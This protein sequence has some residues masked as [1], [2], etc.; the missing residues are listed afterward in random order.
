MSQKFVC[1]ICEKEIAANQSYFAQLCDTCNRSHPLFDVQTR[2]FTVETA[3]I[4]G[5]CGIAVNVNLSAQRHIDQ[6]REFA[7]KLQIWATQLMRD[8]ENREKQ[9]VPRNQNEK[10][11]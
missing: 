1:V 11:D 9:L 7:E 4:S 5:N 6:Q 3:F 8:V 10:R 2:N